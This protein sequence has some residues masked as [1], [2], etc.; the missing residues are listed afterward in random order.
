MRITDLDTNE[1]VYIFPSKIH[2]KMIKKKWTCL[3]GGTYTKRARAIHESTNRHS[4]WETYNKI[5][6]DNNRAD[7]IKQKELL[8][9]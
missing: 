5:A 4:N 2:Q 6:S 1:N 8:V 9:L 7:L 3:C